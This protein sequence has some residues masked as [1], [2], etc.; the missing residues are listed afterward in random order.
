MPAVTL[1]GP[2]LVIDRSAD[3]LTVV[4]TVFEV[5][6]AGTGSEVAEDTVAELDRLAVWD[7]STVTTIEIAGA[8][9][10]ARLA[11]VQ[12]TVVVPVQVQPVPVAETRVVPEGRVSETATLVAVEGPPLETDSV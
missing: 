12:L 6:L 11:R 2:D 9:P 8:A 3:E 4:T 5:L 1:A 7:G 10:G